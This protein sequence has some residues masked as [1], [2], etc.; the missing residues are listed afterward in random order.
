MVGYIPV[1]S[2]RTQISIILSGA[3]C[4]CETNASQHILKGQATLD[5][6]L[7]APR[8]GVFIILCWSWKK[9]RDWIWNNDHLNRATA[10]CIT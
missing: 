8:S 3:A 10:V 4:H 2:G 1:Q 7:L 9:V 6:T 5:S